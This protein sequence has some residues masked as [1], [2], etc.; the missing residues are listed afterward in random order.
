MLLHHNLKFVVQQCALC[1]EVVK[2]YVIT[3]TIIF[4][5]ENLSLLINDAPLFK[6]ENF[7]FAI[8][9]ATLLHWVMLCLLFDL[10]TFQNN[11]I[12]CCTIC[13]FALFQNCTIW[14]C[15]IFILCYFNSVQFNSLMLRY[16]VLHVFMF[17]PFHVSLFNVTLF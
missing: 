1:C 6:V 10:E 2:V 16:L 3:T 8:F 12:W 9:D 7:I 4:T 11:T 5:C 15:T 17:H 13:N 14:C